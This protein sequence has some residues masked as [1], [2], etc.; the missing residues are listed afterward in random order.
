PAEQWQRYEDGTRRSGEAVGKHRGHAERSP[1]DRLHPDPSGP[2]HFRPEAEPGQHAE[3]TEQNQ[4]QPHPMKYE[5]V[6]SRPPH[7]RG[8][9]G[10]RE[11]ESAQP[12]RQ[13]NDPDNVYD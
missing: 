9:E 8:A 1:D 13:E 5:R 7:R 2:A 4:E 3:T 11:G 12:G 6:T 10:R